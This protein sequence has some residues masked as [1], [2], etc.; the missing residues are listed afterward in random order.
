MRVDRNSKAQTVLAST[1]LV[2]SGGLLVGNDYVYVSNFS[3]FPGQGQIVR[4]KR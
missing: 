2:A 3:V 1:G 4:I